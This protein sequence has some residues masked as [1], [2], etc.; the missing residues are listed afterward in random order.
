VCRFR[1]R[2]K[3]IDGGDR[4]N[5]WQTETLH[6]PLYFETFRSSLVKGAAVCCLEMKTLSEYARFAQSYPH[7]PKINAT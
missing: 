7:D 4:R 5:D 6:S 2:S 1:H 3:R